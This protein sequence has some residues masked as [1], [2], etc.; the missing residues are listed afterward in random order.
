MP[1][2]WYWWRKS[3]VMQMILHQELIGWCSVA[4]STWCI[5]F[6]IERNVTNIMPRIMLFRKQCLPCF[7]LN[8]RFSCRMI[9]SHNA[10][11]MCC[12]SQITLLHWIT[13]FDIYVEVF[14]QKLWSTRCI[15]SSHLLLYNPLIILTSL[16]NHALSYCFCF[17]CICRIARQVK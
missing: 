10:F 8:V 16:I 6:S 17:L 11:W 3:Y 9:I 5:A 12:I 13:Y 4:N 2:L 15:L 7:R 1:L 14:L